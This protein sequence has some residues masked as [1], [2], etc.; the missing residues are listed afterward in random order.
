MA[1]FKLGRIKFVWQ[2]TWTIGTGYVVDDVISNGGQSYVCVKNHTA[3]SL[4]STDL[5]NNPTY[6]NLVAGGTNWTGDWAPST[7]YNA[8]D[9]AK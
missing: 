8:G 1:E 2:G 7:Y 3:S 5:N 6:W 9:Q 4:F